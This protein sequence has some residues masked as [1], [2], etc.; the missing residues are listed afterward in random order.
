M[1]LE[2][3]GA[4]LEYG[5]PREQRDDYARQFD[6]TDLDGDGRHS[7]AEYIGG[8]RYLNPQARRGIFAALDTDNDGFV[9]KAE[10]ILN[11]IITD[12]AKA[13][14]QGMDDNGDGTVQRAE[15]LTHAGAKFSDGESASKVFSALDT[16][17]DEALQIPEY[18][19]VWGRWA[20]QGKERPEN[21]LAANPEDIASRVTHHFADNDGVK[22]HYVS[23]GEGPLIVMIHGFPDFWYTWREQMLPLSKAGYQVVAMDLRGYNKS[24]QPKGAD[25]YA[26]HHLVEDVAAVVGA[27]GNTSAT[28]AGHDWGGAIA[29][30]FAMTKPDM[31][32]RLMVLNLPHPRG[33]A[34]ELANDPDQRRSSAYARG[35]QKPGAHLLLNAKVLSKWVKDPAAR[36]RYIEAFERS[37]YE[38]MLNYYKS[39]FPR[40]PYREPEGP[41]AKVGCPVLMLH[42][43]DDAALLAPALNN[44]WDW[45]DKDLTLITIPGAGHFVQ[46]DAADLVTRSML[47]WLGR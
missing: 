47:M 10:Y 42:G 16:N 11:R 20:R 46:Q 32:D 37:D 31:V 41:V 28:I 35:F 24:D 1:V 40:E 36:K 39:N 44:T 38:S 13:I 43:L 23:I 25:N 45:L 6:H 15:F 17:S 18:L 27:T 4:T 8:G 12:E 3:L 14:V 22:I 21:R 19:R 9:S 30:S 7:K 2:Q 29:W 34:R 33:L 26:M 5:V